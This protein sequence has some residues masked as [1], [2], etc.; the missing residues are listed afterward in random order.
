MS[1]IGARKTAGR[2]II[3]GGAAPFSCGLTAGSRSDTRA[4][5]MLTRASIQQRARE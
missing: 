3:A 5:T 1:A 4:A 2:I